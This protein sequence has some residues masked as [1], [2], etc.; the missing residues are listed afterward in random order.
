M[1]VGRDARTRQAKDIETSNQKR[2]GSEGQSADD[3]EGC[4]VEE[5]KKW[6]G[7]ERRPRTLV[8]ACDARW[9]LLEGTT[10]ELCLSKN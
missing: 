8:N 5:K 7:R 10:E 2:D 9:C 4:G 1:L 3:S 6:E